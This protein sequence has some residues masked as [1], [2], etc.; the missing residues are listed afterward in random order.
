MNMECTHKGTLFPA[1]KFEA[2]ADYSC[3]LWGGYVTKNS[4]CN[5]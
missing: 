1:A 5:Q 4:C 3:A 2:N